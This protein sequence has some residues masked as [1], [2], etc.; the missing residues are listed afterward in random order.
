MNVNPVQC[1]EEVGDPYGRLPEITRSCGVYHFEQV[2]HCNN[3]KTFFDR[4][5]A[6]SFY[7]QAK[8]VSGLEYVRIDSIDLSVVDSGPKYGAFLCS[9]CG[10]SSP[11]TFS[12]IRNSYHVN[13]KL[14][15]GQWEP[16]DSINVNQN[17]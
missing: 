4:D 12:Q 2:Y 3:K 10:G 8:D 17:K 1:P 13:F 9:P 11:P 6:Y 15:E 5:S 14:I 16:I 7:N